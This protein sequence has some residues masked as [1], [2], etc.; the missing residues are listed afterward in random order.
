MKRSAQNSGAGEPRENKFALRA[1]IAL[2]LIAA[3]VLISLPRPY[4]EKTYLIEAGGCRLETT[5][6]EAA[7]RTAAQPASGSANSTSAGTLILFHGLAANRKI[8]NYLAEGFALEG[9][10]VFVPDLPGHGRTAGPFAAER[11]EQCGE[12][13]VRELRSRGLAPPDSTILAGHSMGGAMAIRI[14]ARVPVAGVIALSPAPMRAGHGATAETLLFRDPPAL[15]A[16]SLIMNGNLEPEELRGNARDL[17]QPGRDVNSHYEILPRVTHGGIVLSAAALQVAQRWATTALHNAAR[18]FSVRGS[19]EDASM[20][21]GALP[22]RLP[23]FG[24]S[25]GFVG[26]LLIAAPFLREITAMS[27]SG[28]KEIQHQGEPQS[29]GGN[30]GVVLWRGVLETAVVGMLVAEVL[31]YW[32]P[33][34]LVRLFEGDYLA[35]YLLLVGLVLC[36]LHWKAFINVIEFRTWAALGALLGGV[37]LVL[38]FTAWFELSLSEAWLNGARWQLFPLLFISLIP[39]LVAEEI[40]LG[41][42]AAE[43]TAKSNAQRLL[44]ATLYRLLLWL[45][46]V[47]GIL[48]LH[49]G[50]IL[51]VLLVPYFFLLSVLQ[52]RGMDVVRE[53]TGSAAAAALFG[54]ILLAGFFLVIFPLV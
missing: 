49:S 48:I 39:V 44:L 28:T 14:A 54:A 31:R 51:M 45:P 21:A 30:S 13:L 7:P 11:A 43:R 34:R 4:H 8:M 19:G 16:N 18:G 2:V 29:D 40:L 1:T 27:A 36:G 46:L 20:V 35:G 3:G 24:F 42:I 47:F 33:L 41:P 32:T 23:L 5:V 22:S 15:P 26:L 53:V 25:L 17:L 6:F 50:E 37:I 9:L 38:L 52:R 12:N 10:R